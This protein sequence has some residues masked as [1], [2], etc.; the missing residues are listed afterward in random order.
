MQDIIVGLIICTFLLYV[1]I[2][3]GLKE[4]KDESKVADN[5]ISF[6]EGAVNETIK[7]GLC[8]I[9]LMVSLMVFIHGLKL[10]F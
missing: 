10:I 9:G 7:F 4:M 2:S 5:I 1:F 8:L 3:G 6:I